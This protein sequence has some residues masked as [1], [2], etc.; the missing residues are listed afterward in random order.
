MVSQL[1]MMNGLESPST[2]EGV[3]SGDA[4]PGQLSTGY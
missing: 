2:D 3:A 4:N 1:P